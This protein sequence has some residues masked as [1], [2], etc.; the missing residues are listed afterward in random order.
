MPDSYQVEST[1]NWCIITASTELVDQAAAVVFHAA[2]YF[3]SQVPARNVYHWAAGLFSYEDPNLVIQ[4][5]KINHGY[6]KHKSRH[7][8]RC[9]EWKLKK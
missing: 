9:F 1:D 5:L 8:L 4:G 2:D 3:S 6:C 7:I